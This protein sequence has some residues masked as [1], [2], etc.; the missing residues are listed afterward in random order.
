[1]N[2]PQSFRITTQVDGRHCHIDL[3]ATQCT[4]EYPYHELRI[5]GVVENSAYL[6]FEDDPITLETIREFRERHK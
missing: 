5:T 3:M 1:M 6:T 2:K 4:I